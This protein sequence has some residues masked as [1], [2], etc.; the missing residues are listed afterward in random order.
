MVAFIYV[1][2]NPNFQQ[3]NQW[4][5]FRLCDLHISH[6]EHLAMG[7]TLF[8]VIVWSNLFGVS[9]VLSDC[10]GQPLCCSK[11]APGV[12]TECPLSIYLGQSDDAKKPSVAD[13]SQRHTFPFMV[14]YLAAASTRCGRWKMAPSFPRFGSAYTCKLMYLKLIPKSGSD[15]N[16]SPILNIIQNHHETKHRFWCILCQ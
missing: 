9:T 15:Q 7:A 6:L 16:V 13:N 12:L 1:Y 11:W 4:G 10:C 5:S 3:L 8:K 14:R 2:T